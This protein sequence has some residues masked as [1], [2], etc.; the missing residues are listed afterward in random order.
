MTRLAQ[1]QP[2]SAAAAVERRRLLRNRW[3]IILLI[4]LFI[5]PVAASYYTYYVIRP[6]GRTNFGTLIE[7]QRPLP[8]LTATGMDG[9]TVDLR[10]LKGQ[11]L[12]ISVAGGACDAECQ[13]NLYLQRQIRESMGK[14][15]RRVDWVWLV[16]DDQTVPADLH[17]ALKDATVLR[18]PARALRRWLAPA[19]GHQLS[20]HLYVVDPMGH[21]MMRFPPK[22]DKTSAAKA[23]RDLAKL[24]YAS[25]DWDAAGRKPDAQK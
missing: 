7:P 17:A 18:V 25:A 8:E 23:R 10:T 9:K 2:P 22:L 15:M 24:L 14:D 6:S 3:Q 1:N 13:D 12:L 19:A 11:W 20:D 5:A 16:D 21:W 4:V